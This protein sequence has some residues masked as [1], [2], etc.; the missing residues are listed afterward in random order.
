MRL[1]LASAILLVAVP[2]LADQTTGTVVAYDRVAKILVF[3][4]KSIWPL[5]TA[6]EIPEGL[7]AGVTVT[8]D[9]ESD[10]DN[11]LVKIN[12]IRPKS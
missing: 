2:A 4:D 7:A 9:F 11:G 3:S 1:A 5:E 10:G 6:S 8:L 12:S